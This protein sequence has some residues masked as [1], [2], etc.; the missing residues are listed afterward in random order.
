MCAVAAEFLNVSSSQWIWIGIAIGAVVLLIISLLLCCWCRKR[1]LRKFDQRQA[2][3]NARFGEREQAR[4]IAL[5][6]KKLSKQEQH[7]A[8]RK[9]YNLDGASDSQ[10]QPGESAH[11]V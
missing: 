11:D 2:E 3:N 7:D 9:K 1:R 6:D 4:S 8:I 5:Q 10:S